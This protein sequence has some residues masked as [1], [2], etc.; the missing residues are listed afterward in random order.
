MDIYTRCPL[1]G[2]HY[3]IVNTHFNQR[4]IMAS[5]SENKN[6]SEGPLYS[7][8]KTLPEVE[9][10]NGNYLFTKKGQKVFYACSGVA[11]SGLGHRNLRVCFTMI[12][13]ILTGVT[14][15]ASSSWSHPVVKEL[16]NEVIR[17]RT[18]KWPES[19]LVGLV[20][21]RQRLP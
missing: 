1:V 20:Q 10:A 16:T 7:L 8:Y 6:I 18:E 11:V 15:I 4:S 13:Q 17:V 3:S 2:I 9:N 21:R 14:Y 19:S 12:K 5:L